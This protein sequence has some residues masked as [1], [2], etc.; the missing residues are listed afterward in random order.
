MWCIE[1]RNAGFG[2]VCLDCFRGAWR[3]AF[4]LMCLLSIIS[5]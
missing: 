4:S 1:C 5:L 2:D 3:I